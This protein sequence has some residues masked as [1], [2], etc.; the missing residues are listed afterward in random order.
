MA[1]DLVLFFSAIISFFAVHWIFLRVLK[2]AKVKGLVDKPNARKLQENPV[3]VLGGIA[4][5]FGFVCGVLTFFALLHARD[6]IP[7]NMTNNALV[8]IL[9]G[10]VML[11]VGSLDDIMGLTPKTR[12][13]IE[14]LAIL[15]LIYNS[16]MCIDSLHGLWGIDKFSWWIG[17]PLTV[18]AGIGIINAYNM[19]DGVNGLSSGLCITSLCV[20]SCIF[21]KRWDYANSV[22]ALCFAASLVPFLVHNVFGK[23]S[24]MYIGD[25]GTM[26]I[27]L[28]VSWFVIKVLSSKNELISSIKDNDDLTLGLVAMMLAVSCVPVFD[29]LRVMITRILNGKSPFRPDKTHLHHVFIACGVSHSITSLVEICINLFIVMCW[30]IGYCLGASVDVQFY[31][32]VL[33]SMIFVW[34]TYKNMNR[35]YQKHKDTLPMRWAQKTHLGHTRLWLRFQ[36]WLDKGAFEDYLQ[37]Y[38]DKENLSAKDKDTI[39]IIKLL[40]ERERMTIDDIVQESGV[41]R[42]RIYSI[43]TELE[44]KGVV[45]VLTRKDFGAPKKVK[46]C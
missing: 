20:L 43:V 22:I 41:E 42:L 4:V 15:I 31:I 10:C 2:I 37:I 29:T 9:V 32:V 26:V 8:L 5:F 21:W 7:C 28:L 1:N 40:Q 25:A 3:P 24:K 33:L 19:V 38:Q 34:G 30:Y 6:V 13:I 11:Y 17:I 44:G 16:G 18:F 46:M 39:A 12:I 36:R 45:E 23:K 35:L 27:G 14:V